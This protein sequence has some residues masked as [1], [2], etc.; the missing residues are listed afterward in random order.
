MAERAGMKQ[1][2]ISA[3][4]KPGGPR[5]N[6]DTLCRLANAFDVGLDIRFVPF[7]ELVLKSDH[8][9]PDTF[10]VRSFEEE[11]KEAQAEP[12]AEAFKEIQVR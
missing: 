2:R 5:L 11:V 9:N 7:G 6:I 12:P 10:S 1:S 4:E 3:I 8:F